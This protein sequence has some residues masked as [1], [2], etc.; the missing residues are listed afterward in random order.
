MCKNSINLEALPSK[1]SDL[2]AS[3]SFKHC[4]KYIVAILIFFLTKH[5][6]LLHLNYT[7]SFFFNK[8]SRIFV[9]VT[10]LSSHKPKCKYKIQFITSGKQ[11]GTFIIFFKYSWPFT[12]GRC[13]S[14]S[15]FISKQ[16]MATLESIAMMH[17]NGDERSLS[18]ILTASNT[19]FT[20]F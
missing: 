15:S 12:I 7:I 14:P 3:K 1:N 17:T 2:Q 20:Y 5:A 11:N 8:L 6:I 19:D 13:L 18:K 4:I 10:S 9:R 16:L